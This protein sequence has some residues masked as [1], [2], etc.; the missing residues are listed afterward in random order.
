[1]DEALERFCR[2][3]HQR[4]VRALDLVT[5]SL[6]LAEDLAQ[7]TLAR[8]CQQW[9]RIGQLESP[10]GYAHRIAM[11]LAASFFRRRAVQRRVAAELGAHDSVTDSDT[12]TAVA[13]REALQLLRLEQR[14]V[15]VLRY[16]LQHSVAETA[17]ILRCPEGT[18]KTHA[19]RGLQQLRQLLGSEV[20]TDA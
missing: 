11:N 1:V 5:G 6:P 8:V 2:E 12:A 9:S 19:T 16:F 10:G 4:L 17:V 7:E 15:L 14:K 20:V 18:V 3:E 13:V